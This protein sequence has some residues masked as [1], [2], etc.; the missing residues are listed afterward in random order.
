MWREK[1]VNFIF[2]R[3]ARRFLLGHLPGIRHSQR[4]RIVPFKTK[5]HGYTN[6]T[7]ALFFSSLQPYAVKAATVA[8]TNPIRS[9][10]AMAICRPRTP[11]LM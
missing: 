7:R 4:Q 10:G 11:A 6:D 2:P 3:I 9:C 1:V 5:K 8:P